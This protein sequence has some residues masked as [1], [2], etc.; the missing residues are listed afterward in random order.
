M[1]SLTPLLIELPPW[2]D[3]AGLSHYFDKIVVFLL[4]TIVTGSELVSD[5]VAVSNAIPACTLRVHPPLIAYTQCEHPGCK[6][7]DAVVTILT[8]VHRF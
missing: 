2:V 8:T 7:N 5:L 4:E 1:K 6:K 3:S